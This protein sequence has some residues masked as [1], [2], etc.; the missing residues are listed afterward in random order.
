MARM[1]R[2]GDRDEASIDIEIEEELFPSQAL[3]LIDETQDGVIALIGGYGSGKSYVGARKAL[4]LACMN[5]RSR[6]MI[7]GPT[8]GQVM[9]TAYISFVELLDQYEIDY[10]EVRGNRPSIILPWGNP[11]RPGPGWIH[12]RS[13]DKPSSIKGP[14]LGWTW[15]D[16]AG[17]IEKGEEAFDVVLSRLRCQNAALRQVIITTTGEALWLRERFEEDPGDNMAYYRASTT[18]NDTLPPIYI[19]TLKHNLPANLLDVYLE[20]GFM[21]EEFGACYSNFK[22][23]IHVSPFLRWNPALPAV[24]SFDFNVNPHCSIIGQVQNVNGEQCALVF[25]EI[26]IPN[27]TTFDACEIFL[28]KLG[29]HEGGV[30]VYGDPSG[31][32]RSTSSKTTD[33]AII[34]KRYQEVYGSDRVSF[35]YKQ[36]DPGFRARVNAVNALL[37]NTFGKARLFVHPRCKNLIYDLRHVSWT[38]DQKIDKTKINKHTGWTISHVSDGLAYWIERAF[39]ILRPVVT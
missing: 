36:S 32:H 13:L 20:G 38:K 34:R 5:P 14:T 6:G 31:T 17:S 15:I 4:Q 8:H 23:D 28:N 35:W 3:F 33:Y 1:D 7:A 19:E 39:P 24:H 2:T 30:E 9:D 29:R 21:P 12:I 11:R 25:D 16:E 22:S 26:V 27:G 10:R 37:M 18:E